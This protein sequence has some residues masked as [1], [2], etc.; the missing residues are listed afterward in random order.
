MEASQ[1]QRITLKMLPS[2]QVPDQVKELFPGDGDCMEI[3]ARNLTI[4]RDHSFLVET[5]SGDQGSFLLSTPRMRVRF[6]EDRYDQNTIVVKAVLENSLRNWDKDRKRGIACRVTWVTQSGMP[7]TSREQLLQKSRK[8]VMGN[9][10]EAFWSFWNEI[11]SKENQRISERRDSPGWAYNQRRPGLSG[12]IEFKVD[13]DQDAIIEACGGRFLVNTGKEVI[14]SGKR[15]TRLVA[16]ETRRPEGTQWIS[17]WPSKE[18]SIAEI[19]HNGVI[20]PDWVSLQTEFNRRKD[21]LQRLQAGKAAL[22]ELSRFIIE[23]SQLEVDL[24]LFRKLLSTEYNPEQVNAIRKA[25]CERAFTCILGPPGTGKT[26]VI[27]EIASQMAAMGK[28][29][30]IS[31]QSNLAVD[32]ALEKILDTPDVFRVRV[33]RP[34]AVKLNPELLLER[35]SERYRDRLFKA[36][37]DAQLIEAQELSEMSVGLPSGD[38]LDQWMSEYERYR[39]LQRSCAESELTASNARE[40]FRKNKAAENELS[41]SLT[42]ICRRANLVS[43][44]LEDYLSAVEAL[45]SA[46]VDLDAAWQHR[47]RIASIANNLNQLTQIEA[48][49]Q[50]AQA[51]GV[52]KTDLGI[53]IR[54]H[55]Q[56]IASF[57]SQETFFVRA[58]AEN[59]ALLQKRNNAGFFKNLWSQLV[60]T[61][62]DIL[63]LERKLVEARLASTKAENFL[64]SLRTRRAQFERRHTEGLNQTTTAVTK[65][66][67]E[68]CTP[69]S[70]EWKIK[71]LQKDRQM[72]QDAH[73]SGA[74]EYLQILNFRTELATASKNLSTA[75]SQLEVS[76]QA[77]ELSASSL[78]QAEADFGAAINPWPEINAVARTL[79]FSL[80]NPEQTHVA[81]IRSSFGR[82]R[83]EQKKIQQRA[84]QWPRVQEALDRY[85][86]RLSQS[87]VDLQQAVLAEANVVAATCS[88]IAGAKSFDSDFD[89]VIIDES[90]RANPLDLLMPAIKGKSVVLVGDHKQLPPF[91]GEELKDELSATD[92]KEVER[93]VF[94][95]VFV[96]SHSSR[97]QVLQTQFRMVPA[98]CDIVRQISY[99]DDVVRL[100]SDESTKARAHQVPN[101]KPVHWIR[102]QGKANIAE[103]LAGGGLINR[104]EVRAVIAAFEMIARAMNDNPRSKKYELGI[105]AM[106][107]RQAGE[108]ERALDK[109]IASKRLDITQLS[110][111]IGT[112]DSFQGREKDA[113]IV[114][115]SETDPARRRF[116]YDRRRLNVALSRAR[117][118]LVI[119]GSIDVLG[120][121]L[122]AFGQP[123]PI[124]KLHGLINDGVRTNC[125]SK[126]SFDAK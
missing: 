97:K 36:S 122:N 20:K 29:V 39:L 23:G 53:E 78:K 42:D 67:G 75:L 80:P 35:A 99:D 79:R 8:N 3:L 5:S 7:G 4:D 73:K 112:V 125:V 13:D 1:N 60:D 10:S 88:G 94:E 33:G 27:A 37:K 32:N 95:T 98:I 59:F 113:V 56:A 50:D 43:T 14:R 90:G 86:Q 51:D 44:K 77:M 17:G 70:L 101:V 76:R 22:P 30:L 81:D 84:T 34:E 119:V 121:K 31:S 41:N 68:Y 116:F 2:S 83:E 26:S 89:C 110:W 85:H 11:L 69:E 108:V 49:F 126:E 18:V 72:Y 91:V 15:V 58:K 71:S 24:P 40:A 16:F 6:F 57:K 28:R 105:I 124:F 55:E 109:E 114:S 12:A 65:L 111:E 46:G 9:D 115:F 93:S 107:K 61:E 66:T 82:L 74:F 52:K 63:G 62:H 87:L 103:S 102:P 45:E 48:K 120:A 118:L 54:G 21:A 117:E 19:P 64:P 47:E 96:R 38:Q 104:A 106:Y 123:N 100:E 25:L 92:L